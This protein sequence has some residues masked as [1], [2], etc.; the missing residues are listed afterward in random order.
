MRTLTLVLSTA[1]LAFS[2]SAIAAPGKMPQGD[3]TRAQAQQH[4]AERFTKMDANRD[5]TLNEADRAA[6]HAMMFDK[7]DADKDGS[8]SKAEMEAMRAHHGGKRG[9]RMAR[10]DG[11]PAPTEAQKTDRRAAMFARVDTDGNGAVSRAEFDAM[12][13]KMG[14][15]MGGK[16]GKRGGGKMDGAITLQAFVANALT[17]FDKTDANRDGTVTQAERQAARESMRKEWQAK[18]AAR[19]QG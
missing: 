6:R 9:D 17:R 12:H 7:L 2:G 16:M 19:Q 10:R 1:A 3:M 18:K 8:V 11:K 4:A 13:A 5:G 15:R 14:A